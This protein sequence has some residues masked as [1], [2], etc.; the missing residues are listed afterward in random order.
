MAN[1]Q[2]LYTNLAASKTVTADDEAASYPGENVIT[3]N[4]AEVW[5]S[6]DVS[7]SYGVVIDLGSAQDV[8][9]AVIGN[10]NLNSGSTLKVQG[11]AS[12]VWTSPSVDQTVTL[13]NKTTYDRNIFKDLGGTFSYR[14]WR[15]LFDDTSLTDGFYECGSIYLGNTVTLTDNF[16]ANNSKQL[17][18]DNITHRTEY[19]QVHAYARDFYHEIDLSFTNCEEATVN[20]LRALAFAVQGTL[21][22]FFFIMDPDDPFDLYYVRLMSNIGIQRIHYDVFSAS[23]S[24]MEET[25]GLSVPRE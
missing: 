12:D 19:G 13:T 17:I 4:Y 20:E 3:K 1:A 21:T 22:P 7:S 23:M 2:L 18:H 25:V 6:S 15:I 14:Y 24:L 10:F 16:D 11:N 5:R 8:S 9:A